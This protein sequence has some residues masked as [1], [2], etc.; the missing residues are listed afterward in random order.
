VDLAR[1]ML[2]GQCLYCGGGKPLSIHQPT[3]P[4]PDKV[5]RLVNR[6][7]PTLLLL[8]LTPTWLRFRGAETQKVVRK[9][10]GR[11]ARWSIC[12]GTSRHS[13][14]MLSSPART[15]SSRVVSHL[16]SYKTQEDRGPHHMVVSHLAVL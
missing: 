15:K 2:V 9:G 11:P 13:A 10:P 5:I 7:V 12:S 3:D 4:I 16:G 14:C 1:S 6:W 8:R